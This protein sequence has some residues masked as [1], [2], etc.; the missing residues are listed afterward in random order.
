MTAEQIEQT[1]QFEAVR[2][3][4]REELC[5]KN[6]LEKDAFHMAERV[7]R[8]NGAPCGFYFC[9]YGP[10]SVRLTAVWDIQKGSIFFYDSLGRR[11]A[12][13]PTPAL[14]RLH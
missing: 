11:V 8:K 9:I 10:R 4:V 13:C 6:Q 1:E 7:L 14:N 5:E 12:N 3:F 2:E